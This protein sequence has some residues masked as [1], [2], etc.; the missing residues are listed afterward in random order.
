MSSDR[1][2]CCGPDA[3]L[4]DG[5]PPDVPPEHADAYLRGYRRG[6]LGQ[7]AEPGDVESPDPGLPSESGFLTG[8]QGASRT[9]DPGAPRGSLDAANQT[10]RPTRGRM[11]LVVLLILVVALL[12]LAAYG[13]GRL[14]AA[15][16]SR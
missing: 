5:V 7:P 10:D 15:G 6:Y 9:A 16:V 12:L 4:P 13:V 3:E 2:E 14:V 1:P 8:P 11:P